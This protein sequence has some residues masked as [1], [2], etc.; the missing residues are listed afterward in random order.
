MSFFKKRAN[1][2]CVIGFAFAFLLAAPLVSN[3][4]AQAV[5]CN[6]NNTVTAEVVVFD[7]AM[8]H[9]RL[10]AQN[11]NW[12]MYALRRD[13]I[14]IDDNLPLT[15]GGAAIKGRVALR[16]DKRPRPLVLRVPADQCLKIEFQNLLADPANPVQDLGDLE[17]RLENQG[18]EDVNN[19]ETP[20]PFPAIVDDQVNSR[21][22]GVHVAGLQ[23]VNSIADDASFVGNNANSTVSPGNSATYP[24]YAE[25]EGAFLL[26]NPSTAIGGE[27]SGGL[28]EASGAVVFEGVR[29]GVVGS[30]L[31]S[32]DRGPQQLPHQGW[33]ALALQAHVVDRAPR[34]SIP[35]WRS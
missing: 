20:F 28:I 27:A 22:A 9:N 31:G 16:P 10:G 35:S 23:L 33:L 34:E 2:L 29:V 19:N 32:V 7:T 3:D 18:L 11:P 6:A 21:F 15:N 1:F 5:V 30:P 12:I 26:S 17:E 4:E 8:V 24:Y 14:N 13:T 25:H